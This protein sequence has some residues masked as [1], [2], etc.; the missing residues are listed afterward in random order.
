MMETIFQPYRIIPVGSHC[1][2]QK[3]IVTGII[4][5]KG[6]TIYFNPDAKPCNNLFNIESDIFGKIAYRP[7]NN[8]QNLIEHTCKYM[9]N[10]FNVKGF[11]FN[12]T[13]DYQ[14][15]GLASSSALVIA[16]INSISKVY[17]LKFSN[18]ELVNH[19]LNIEYLNGKKF[20]NVDPYLLI[21]GKPK[22]LCIIDCKTMLYENIKIPFNYD[23]QI[24]KLPEREILYD[25]KAQEMFDMAKELGCKTLIEVPKEILMENNNGT[26]KHFINEQN[27]IQPFIDS[28]KTNNK[29]IFLDLIKQSGLS[30][31]H[32][33]G[34]GNIDDYNEHLTGKFGRHCCT[35]NNIFI[36]K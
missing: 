28:V 15:G 12:I 26:V 20:G 31:V 29:N 35:K 33:Y 7:K 2:H 13:S 11:D 6:I 27:R 34:I 5:D 9:Y 10:N 19:T 36:I 17:N 24:I 4:I 22:H 8:P 16:I 23:I 30:S 18:K 3:G 25:N 1:D 21:Y 14:F 32:D